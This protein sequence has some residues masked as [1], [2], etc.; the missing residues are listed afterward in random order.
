[1]LI[2]IMSDKAALV[3]NIGLLVLL[4]TLI[5]VGSV[6]LAGKIICA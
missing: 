2:W 1:M 5:M 3:L 6:A 4:T